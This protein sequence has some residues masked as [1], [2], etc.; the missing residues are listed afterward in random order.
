MRVFQTSIEQMLWPERRDKDPVFGNDNRP[1]V[2][3]IDRTTAKSY[4][5]VPEGYIP[6]PLRPLVGMG[7]RL[8]PFLFQN[9]DVR[10]GA[11]PQGTPT[12]LL[13]NMD[14][15]AADEDF[16]ERLKHQEKML[17][18][19][20]KAKHDLKDD[21]D[22]GNADRFRNLVPDMIALSKC[23]DYVTN[24]GHYFGTSYFS[25]EA[26]LTDF[27]KRALIAFLKTF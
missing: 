18:L 15:L 26:A 20:I 10:I 21:D 8:F 17:D 3:H 5:W 11:I 14:M 19:F 13:G 12:S 16:G 4:I 25:E 27:D 1:G 22:T 7:R 2:G 23:R 24:K 9:G 6:A